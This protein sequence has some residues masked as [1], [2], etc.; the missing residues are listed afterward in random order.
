[1]GAGPRGRFRDEAVRRHGDAGRPGAPNAREIVLD[2]KGLAIVRS[3]MMQDGRCPSPS[4]PPIPPRRSAHRAA[5]RRATDP[6]R[7]HERARRR[8]AAVA[9]T[10]QT[11]ASAIPSCSARVRR[12]HRSWI[13]TR[14]PRHPPDLGGADQC[15]EPCAVVMSGERLTPEARKP[16]RAARLPVRMD[17]PV[18]PY[19]IAVASATSPC[20]S[21]AAHRRLCRAG[22]HQGRGGGAR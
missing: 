1:M 9:R 18:A 14:Q 2:S 20:R 5:E 21:S 10:E 15:P 8:G 19:L 11:A 7:L 12:S 4:A 16:A 3:A 13:P 17:K 22:D 6:H